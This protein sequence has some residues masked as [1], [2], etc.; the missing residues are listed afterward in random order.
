MVDLDYKNYHYVF[1]DTLDPEK[2]M[3]SGREKKLRNVEYVESNKNTSGKSVWQGDSMYKSYNDDYE[4]NI[5]DLSDGE[6]LMLEGRF[7]DP[8]RDD[9]YTEAEIKRFTKRFVVKKEGSNK[10]KVYEL[11]YRE[12]V[13]LGEEK[14]NQSAS[15]D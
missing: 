13:E 15:F 12:A 6:L 11:T 9:N 2:L 8:D 10:C 7:I 1:E 3:M 14:H 5:R 4:I